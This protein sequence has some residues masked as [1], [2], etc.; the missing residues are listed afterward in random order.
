MKRLLPF[1]LAG[2]FASGCG[3]G[4]QA[5]R[6]SVATPSSASLTREAPVVIGSIADSPRALAVL[7]E[8]D[9]TPEDLALDAERQGA[10]VLTYLD[11]E[12]GMTIAELAPGSGY[13][14]EL[15]ARSVGHEGRLFAENPPSLLAKRGLDRAWDERLKRP[16]TARVVR[17]D[18]ELGV[19]L[20]LRGFDLVYVDDGLGDL[21]PDA[22]NAGAMAAW[23]ALR[24]GGRF[25]VV[26]RADAGS[27]IRRVVENCGF[28]LTS[29][30]RFLRDGGRTLLTFT[31]P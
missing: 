21:T 29:E 28:R 30:G 12:P 10:D 20:P 16:V 7:A 2:A 8:P 9:R 5:Q 27:A 3:G 22:V 13:F 14:T 24:E 31:R 1:A 19:P 18:S 4:A 11:V 17:L 23:H 15:L 25:V 26:D 6:V